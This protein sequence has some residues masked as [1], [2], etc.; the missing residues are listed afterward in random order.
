MADKDA[1]AFEKTEKELNDW[2][3][4]CRRNSEELG[5]PTI[6][7]IARMISHVQAQTAHDQKQALKQKKAIRKAVRQ[8]RKAWKE[9]D[10]P[11]DSKLI[12]EGLGYAEHSLTAQGKETKNTGVVVLAKM[13]LD[14]RSARVDAVVSQLPK[15]ANTCIVRSYKFGQKDRHASDDMH[16]RI[17]EYSQRRR[18][19][20]EQVALKLKQ[21]YIRPV[22]IKQTAP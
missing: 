8:A 13:Q 15:W 11:V 6:S 10:P 14:S 19:A 16:M 1:D 18:A 12:A 17:G 3:S 21:R 22:C 4:A 20:V 7:G 9:G 2:G 5:L